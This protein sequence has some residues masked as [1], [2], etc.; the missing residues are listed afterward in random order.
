MPTSSQFTI[1]HPTFTFLRIREVVLL[2]LILSL[3]IGIVGRHLRPRSA[4]K[5]CPVRGSNIG[6]ADKRSD[7]RDGNGIWLRFS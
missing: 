5:V 7:L 1:T 2:T 6:S 4:A 3:D